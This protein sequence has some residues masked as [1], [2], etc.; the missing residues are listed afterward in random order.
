MLPERRR[1][2]VSFYTQAGRQSLYMGISILDGVRKGDLS[3]VSIILNRRN[4]RLE[5][6]WAEK[7][8]IPKH[9][10]IINAWRQRL[11]RSSMCLGWSRE[12]RRIDPPDGSSIV[13]VEGQDFWVVVVRF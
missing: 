12:V 8:K 9:D 7:G 1:K 10:S 11:P 13:S 3:S 4:K 2:S 5:H 6:G